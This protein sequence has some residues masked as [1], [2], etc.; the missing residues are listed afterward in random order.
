MNVFIKSTGINIITI[1]FWY[2]FINYKFDQ[3]GLEHPAS[4]QELEKISY[5]Q[6]KMRFIRENRSWKQ[7]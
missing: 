4:M 6:K 7:E 5:I 1:K 2:K 3:K